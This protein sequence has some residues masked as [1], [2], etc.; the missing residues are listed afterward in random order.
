MTSQSFHQPVLVT[1]QKFFL[2]KCIFTINRNSKLWCSLELT[3]LPLI[4]LNYASKVE[5]VSEN[6]PAIHV[7]WYWYGKHA[8]LYVES[9]SNSGWCNFLELQQWQWH[10]MQMHRD[11]PRCSSGSDCDCGRVLV[12]HRT[13]LPPLIPYPPPI[14]PS[15]HV[16]FDLLD[17]IQF[18]GAL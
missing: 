17:E 1:F 8:G 12:E 3:V 15:F 5:V 9:S 7:R 13:V 2:K 6:H 14:L 16:V 11:P 18:L 4:S 10:W